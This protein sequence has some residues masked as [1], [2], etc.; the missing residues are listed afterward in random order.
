MA[1]IDIGKISEAL[2]NKVDLPRPT[3]PQDAVDYV[4]ESQEP[5]SNNSYTWYRKYKSGWVE[6]GGRVKLNG[7]ISATNKR[8]TLPVEMANTNYFCIASCNA[9]VSSAAYVGWEATTGFS[10]GITATATNTGTT[11]WLVA[12]IAKQ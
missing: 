11:T 7:Q 4:V 6:Q 12:G 10:I 2:N 9:N 8:I 1:D 5:T 3:V